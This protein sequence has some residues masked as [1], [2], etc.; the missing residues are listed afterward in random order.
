M[1]TNLRVSGN[2]SEI[3]VSDPST[4]AIGDREELGRETTMVDVGMFER[5]QAAL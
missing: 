5:D 1:S 4:Y 3:I 2:E